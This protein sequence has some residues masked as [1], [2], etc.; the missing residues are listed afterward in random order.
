MDNSEQDTG[1]CRRPGRTVA[2]VGRP[3]VGKSAV[4]N[5]IAGKRIAI[6][7]NESGVTRDRLSREIASPSG[8]FTLIDT[9]GIMNIDRETIHDRID[10]GIRMQAEAALAG[11]SAAI[12]VTDIISGATPLDEEAASVLRKSGIKVFVAANKADTP[13]KDQAAADFSRWGFPVYPVSALH[14]RGFEDLMDAVMKTLPPP[15]QTGEQE[16]EPP[17]CVAIVGRPN[18]GKS[19][20]INKLLRTERVIVSDTP[21]TTRDSIDIPFAVDGRRYVLIDTAGARREAR[22]DTAVERYS[23]YRMQESV[24]R[25][26]ICVLML[27]AE[28]GAGLLDKQLAGE[29]TEQGKG[30]VVAVNKWDL[31]TVKQRE[32]IDKLRREIPFMSYC[33]VVFISAKTGFNIKSLIGA[34]DHVAVQSRSALPTAV[35]NRVISEACEQSPPPSKNGRRLRIYYAVQVG[36]NPIGIRIFVNDPLR[37]PENYK[38]YLIGKIREKFGL[39]GVV[40]YLQFRARPQAAG[41]NRPQ[42]GSAEKRN[43]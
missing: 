40:V 29:I 14:G 11:A 37:A 32:Y 12:L 42:T 15:E 13:E 6:V 28:R 1:D 41:A 20:F 26:D 27:D 24:L 43:K 30:C 22:V 35:L 21:G 16:E 38:A 34:V 17:L 33:P 5:R 9:G 39:E 10:S 8:P 36:R 4:F 18:A 23:R 2:I 19:S 3:N 7:H 31:S 25:A